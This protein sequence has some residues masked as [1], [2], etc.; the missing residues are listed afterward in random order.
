MQRKVKA[1]ITAD[2]I[3]STKTEIIF[4]EKIEEIAQDLQ[5]KIPAFR[6]E[7]SRGDTFQ[8]LIDEPHES[9]WM[10]LTLKAGLRRNNRYL[11]K[12]RSSLKDLLDARF[13]LGIGKINPGRPEETLGSMT[14][15]A[16]MHSGRALDT[17]KKEGA[18]IKITTDNQELN[19]E[20]AAVMPLIGTITQRWSSQQ[21]QAVYLYLLHQATQAEMGKM[22]K[23][24]QRGAGKRLEG[25]NIDEILKYEQYFRQKLA[26]KWTI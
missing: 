19:E 13:S 20:F 17:M 12:G 8:I 4:K 16:F 26:K 18:I 6:V 7:I 11:K 24:S 21:A 2:I 9:L 5:K 22:L 23:I 10:V 1:V 14:G 25:S 15:D 3:D